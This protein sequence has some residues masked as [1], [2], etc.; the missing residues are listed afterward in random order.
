MK[1]KKINAALG[2]LSIAAMLLHIGYTVFAYLAFYYNP[3]LKLVT[4]IPF[5]ALA[6]LHAV[7]GMLTVFLQAD[8]TR[9]DLYPKQNLRTQDTVSVEPIHD[10]TAAL[11]TDDRGKMIRRNAKEISIG[12]DSTREQAF[13]PQR[14]Q[15]TLEELLPTGLGRDA[16]TALL[17]MHSLQII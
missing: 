6:C 2:L 8:G 13:P 12:L 3:T 7:C 16:D 17:L 4:A 14:F 10:T 1:L 11:L 5:M 9:L 15:K